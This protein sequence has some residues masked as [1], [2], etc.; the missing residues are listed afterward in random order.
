RKLIFSSNTLS[1]PGNE[2]IFAWDC[3]RIALFMLESWIHDKAQP[4]PKD[5]FGR[6][7][8]H[9]FPMFGEPASVIKPF[10]LFG[11][12]NMQQKFEPAPWRDSVINFDSSI[13]GALTFLWHLRALLTGTES[14][15]FLK[16]S[17][18]MPLV[19]SGPAG[20]PP[21]T[22]GQATPGKN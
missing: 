1:S 22:L 9:G 12:A 7:D 15:E 21:T 4:D 6:I 10:P 14:L 16:S 17:V 11:W 3:A 19:S 5:V 8:R 18:F 20:G 13:V 2:S